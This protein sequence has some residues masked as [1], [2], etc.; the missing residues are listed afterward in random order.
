[1]G[2]LLQAYNNKCNKYRFHTQACYEP[3]KAAPGV[4]V[5]PGTYWVLG[6]DESG[7]Y[8][9]I[10]ISCEYLWVPVQNMQPNFDSVWQ[11]RPLPTDVVDGTASGK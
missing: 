10:I 5:N 9:K 1:M 2:L 8:Y 6:V 11:G 7:E 3:G 4:M